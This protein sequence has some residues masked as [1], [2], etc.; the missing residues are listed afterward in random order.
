MDI[1]LQCDI[2]LSKKLRHV[3]GEGA[4]VSLLIDYI[5]EGTGGGRLLISTEDEKAGNANE[6][7]NKETSIMLTP[8]ELLD[9]VPGFTPAVASIFTPGAQ[10]SNGVTVDSY[11]GEQMVNPRTPVDR[12]A[13]T[14]AP[15]S[16]YETAHALKTEA[17]VQTPQVFSETEIPECKTYIKDLK[18]LMES[19][20]NSM[21]KVS[22]INIE[23][24]ADPRKRAVA[25]ENKERAESIGTPAFVVNTTCA[26]LSI[27]DLELGL[28]LNVPY[29]LG[30][31]SAKRLSEST[32]LKSMLRANLIKFINPDD[33]EFYM[34]KAGG[35]I[36]NS[37]LDTF[38]SHREAEAAIE[39]APQADEMEISVN[40]IDDI[41]EQQRLATNLTPMNLSLETGGIRRSTHGIARDRKSVPSES[42]ANKSGIKTIKK[43]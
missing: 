13:T 11:T 5:H 4:R 34:N 18:E 26:S 25:R 23:A 40:E 16:V 28:M 19:V 37:G 29:N 22:D 36:L 27:N 43:L 30:N 15:E 32:D 9:E 12:I 7:L 6:L 38:G 14:N 17:E 1:T 8:R 41:T 20:S 33:V 24:I 31:I 10:T 42:T 35:E 39:S 2:S 3:V 21:H